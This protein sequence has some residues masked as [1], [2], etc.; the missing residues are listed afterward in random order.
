VRKDNSLV[1]NTYT[2]HFRLLFLRAAHLQSFAAAGKDFA[3]LRPAYYA[4]L[5][6]VIG[7]DK[8]NTK[9]FRP[10]TVR[11]DA[12]HG[13][14]QAGEFMHSHWKSFVCPAFAPRKI[15]ICWNYKF[16]I[17]GAAVEGQEPASLPASLPTSSTSLSTN[18]ATSLLYYLSLG[19]I[20]GEN[21]VYI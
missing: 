1:V 13:T 16:M 21:H 2:V 7:Q 6:V 4:T 12:R 11:H 15:N 10:C 14:L 9:T 19:G 17:Q 8:E 18:L 5:L 20:Q 3:A